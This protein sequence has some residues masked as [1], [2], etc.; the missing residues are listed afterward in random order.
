MYYCI[1]KIRIVPM[2]TSDAEV[3]DDIIRVSTLLGHIPNVPEYRTHGKFDRKTVARRFGGTWAAGMITVFGSAYVPAR[4]VDYVHGSCAFCN[5][6][7]SFP[8][9][10][11]KKYCSTACSNRAPGRR[12]RKVYICSVCGA[13]APYRRTLCIACRHQRSI[14]GKTLSVYADKRNDC[15]R[16][17]EIRAN[18]RAVAKVL[19]DS[20]KVCG[21][22]KSVAVCHIKPITSFSGDTPISVINDISNLVKLCR[23]H[24]WELDSGLLKLS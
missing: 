21:Y 3:R 5:K 22:D 17:S 18:A 4:H 11:P 14:T 24:H 7:M 16:Y 23:N 1:F 6:P 8:Y 10:A 9:S 15:G 20:C 12:K 13:V 19:P 2:K